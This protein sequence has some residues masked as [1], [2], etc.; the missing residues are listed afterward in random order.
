MAMRV[1]IWGAFAVQILHARTGPQLRSGPASHAGSFAHLSAPTKWATNGKAT[2][3]KHK[4]M[5]KTKTDRL[6]FILRPTFQAA[7]QKPASLLA[8]SVS[9][10][11]SGGGLLIDTLLSVGEKQRRQSSSSSALFVP[12]P[13]RVPLLARARLS[14]RASVC[15][16]VHTLAP[17]HRN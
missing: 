2:S 7:P 11:E 4:S 8:I 6:S 17:T 16:S 15:A 13:I 3:R 14:V 12:P 5:N 1:S 10:E 9:G